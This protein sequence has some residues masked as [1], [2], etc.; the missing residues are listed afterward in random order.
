MGTSTEVGGGSQIRRSR[1][2]WRELLEQFERSGQSREEFC[3]EQGLTVGHFN[4]QRRALSK[5]VSG[6]AVKAA[7]PLFL[8]VAARPGPE[9]GAWDVELQLGEG[10]FLRLRRPC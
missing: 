5:A 1:D 3:R 10:V 9:V 6:P 4:R 2:Q 7:Q 8:E